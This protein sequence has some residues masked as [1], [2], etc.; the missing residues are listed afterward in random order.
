ML[1]RR[2]YKSFHFYQSSVFPSSMGGFVVLII[3]TL[4]VLAGFSW[5]FDVKGRMLMIYDGYRTDKLIDTHAFVQQE[6]APILLKEGI[7]Y[8]LSVADTSF[9]KTYVDEENHFSF[10][11]PNG[12]IVQK[13]DDNYPK[14][15][16]SSS[17]EYANASVGYIDATLVDPPHDRVY[18][19]AFLG[20]VYS[21]KELNLY[22][23][24]RTMQNVANHKNWGTLQYV[25][26]PT[27]IAY[28][29]YYCLSPFGDRYN[30]PGSDNENVITFYG[31]EKAVCITLGSSS[32]SVYQA[33][34]GIAS[35]FEFFPDE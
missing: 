20:E 11:Y 14:G 19:P 8:Q 24:K 27:Y 34:K 5:L 7:P 23:V 18:N 9:W 31:K 17:I 21:Y 6:I 28:V 35:T 32:A 15:M 29:G 13:K 26:G 30:T 12:L 1:D 2:S 25:V 3:I 16:L 33:I 4:L 10:Q 22:H